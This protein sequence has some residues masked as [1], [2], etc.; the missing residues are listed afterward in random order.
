MAFDNRLILPKN[1][2]PI[3]YKLHLTPDLTNFNFYGEVSIKVTIKNP[4]HEIV[5]N[6]AE[7][8][9]E[10]VSVVSGQ[11][12]VKISNFKWPGLGSSLG[13]AVG[14]RARNDGWPRR[15]P[16]PGQLKLEILN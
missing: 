16:S 10:N 14:R 11:N 6:S 1:V 8:E 7:L 15:C 13:A 9:I 12:T 5:L 2:T 3:N 4:S